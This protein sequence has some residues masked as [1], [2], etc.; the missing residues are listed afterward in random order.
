MCSTV[1]QTRGMSRGP[2]LATLIGHTRE[3][4]DALTTDLTDPDAPQVQTLLA[5]YARFLVDTIPGEDPNPKCDKC[6]DHRR[7]KPVLGMQIIAGLKGD[8]GFRDWTWD[9]YVS[10]GDT[11][12]IAINAKT[13]K[14]IWKH[15]GGAPARGINYWESKDRSDQRLVTSTG[16]RSRL[17]LTSSPSH[18]PARSSSALI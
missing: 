1:Q 8:I 13:G 15:A 17:L 14:E 9:A 12:I 5:A 4:T 10:R 11:N 7:N 6:R 18:R 16:V 3:L 2:R